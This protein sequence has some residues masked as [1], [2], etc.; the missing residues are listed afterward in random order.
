MNKPES[1][2]MLRLSEATSQKAGEVLDAAASG[3][4]KA[5]KAI[6]NGTVKGCKAIENT[7]V[8]AF[9]RREGE[10]TAQAK[11]RVQA[12]VNGGMAP[13][14]NKE[15]ADAASAEPSREETK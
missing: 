2:E 3:T 7:V 11:A 14:Q 4:V 6:E 15:K 1:K 10:T 8:G 13:A 12:Q 9:L 5:Y